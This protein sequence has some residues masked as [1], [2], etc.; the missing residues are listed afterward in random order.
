MTSPH[1]QLERDLRAALRSVDHVPVSSDAWQQNQRRL[2]AAPHRRLPWLVAA[3]AVVLAVLLI[4]GLLALVSGGSDSSTPANDGGSN[5]SSSSDDVFADEN[6]LGPV[7]EVETLTIDGETAVHEAV[8]SD[9]SGKGPSLCDRVTTL[10][11]SSG[12]PAAARQPG[13]RT[14]TSESV[15]FDWL[16]GTSGSGDH[17]WRPGWRRRARH[18]GADLD[19]QRRH[20]PR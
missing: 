12:G 20:D 17:P 11:Q 19:G 5:D 16:S 2:A 13:T 7:V 3:A 1:D 8:L 9:T 6:L 14:P 4:G 18:E 10:D 15:A